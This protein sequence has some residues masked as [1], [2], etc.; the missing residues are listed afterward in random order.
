M[1]AGALLINNLSSLLAGVYALCSSESNELI[2]ETLCGCI[3]Y[4]YVSQ[5]TDKIL[6]LID[7]DT[8]LPVEKRDQIKALIGADNE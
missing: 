5:N 2:I 6:D 1:R 3:P 7:A 4:L 8:N